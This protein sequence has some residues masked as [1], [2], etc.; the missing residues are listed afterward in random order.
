MTIIIVTHD[1]RIAEQTQRV[2][3]LMDGLL[4]E[5]AE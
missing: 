1:P 4:V 2:L 5:G 3:R